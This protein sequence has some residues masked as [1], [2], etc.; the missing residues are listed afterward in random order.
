MDSLFKSIEQRKSYIFA[1]Y[2]ERPLQNNNSKLKFTVL[3]PNL[4]SKQELPIFCKM[5]FLIKQ[6]SHIPVKIRLGDIEYVDM[7]E[8][9]SIHFK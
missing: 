7:L 2:I 3:K 9:K 4:F 8:S 5:E 1:Q 6:N